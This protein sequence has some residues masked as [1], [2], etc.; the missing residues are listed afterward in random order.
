MNDT[1]KAE[2]DDG[3]VNDTE[4]YSV[5]VGA[6]SLKLKYLF[7]GSLGLFFFALAVSE[8]TEDDEG[9]SCP[10][11][12]KIKKVGMGEA[13]L[14][15]EQEMPNNMW[16]RVKKTGSAPGLLQVKLKEKGV[17]TGKIPETH[18]ITAKKID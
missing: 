4:F 6:F 12:C 10:N 18:K 15:V 17:F 13:E 8:Y 9:N 16:T 7:M 1:A 3:L 11:S 14:I 5:K 2:Y